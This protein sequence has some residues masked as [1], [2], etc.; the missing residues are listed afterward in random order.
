MEMVGRT[1]PEGRGGSG[2]GRSGTVAVR[3][4]AGAVP[5][6]VHVVGRRTGGACHVIVEVSEIHKVMPKKSGSPRAHSSAR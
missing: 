2:V 1:S 6:T 3:T 5:A 4:V